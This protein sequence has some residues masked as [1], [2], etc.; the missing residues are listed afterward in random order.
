MYALLRGVPSTSRTL[1]RLVLTPYLTFTALQ[2][3]RSRWV[4]CSASL[5]RRLGL[6]PRSVGCAGASGPNEPPR[7]S[8]VR[9]QTRFL[10]STRTLQPRTVQPN[11]H[12][13]G[14]LLR[15]WAEIWRELPAANR[16]LQLD[17]LAELRTPL[18]KVAAGGAAT[19][20]KA[21]QPVAA[22]GLSSVA[23]TTGDNTTPTRPSTNSN[24]ASGASG[25][26]PEAAVAFSRLDSE[27]ALVTLMQH[28]EALIAA[29]TQGAEAGRRDTVRHEGHRVGEIT[30]PLC[31]PA[32][33][34]P[35]SSTSPRG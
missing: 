6:E 11:R 17:L 27:S 14:A 16:S 30:Q 2:E 1:T 12:L 5:C 28:A 19:V 20:S 34:P 31:P 15:S 7:M 13:A 9:F 32:A 33:P 35:A 26:S 25:G 23:A 29:G 24:A 10:Y 18:R 22:L 21:K 8:A 4:A 3:G